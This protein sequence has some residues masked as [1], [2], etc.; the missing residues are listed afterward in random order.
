VSVDQLWKTWQGAGQPLPAPLSDWESAAEDADSVFYLAVMAWA[1]QDR[2]AATRYAERAAALEPERRVFTETARF[3]RAGQVGN[4][5]RAPE[6]FTAFV[7]GGSN[8][9]LYEATTAALR[10]CYRRLRPRTLLDIGTG[11]GMALLPALTEDVGEVE[12]VEPMDQL[13]DRLVAAL[14][15]RGV[16]HR[17]F[18]GTFAEF[19]AA[20]PQR[21]WA[22]AQSTFALHSLP[23]H[24]RREAL[25]WLR[26]RTDRLLLVEFDVPGAESPFEPDWYARCLRRMEQGLAE[27]AGDGG[28]VAQGF[29]IPVMLGYFESPMGEGTR[30]TYEQAVSAWQADLRAAGFTRLAE[31]RLLYDY[32][33]APAYLLEAA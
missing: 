9:A 26:A 14:R 3:L 13:V 16:A 33:W 32:W 10:E 1:G 8:V 24:Q 29:L 2:T 20:Y 6:A 31:P 30:T 23:Y 11:E 18:R 19:A 4:V 25:A 21:R 15:E 7:Q 27:Y 22:L 12:V 5:Y 17:A 28:L